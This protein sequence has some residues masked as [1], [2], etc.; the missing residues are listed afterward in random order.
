MISK[1][2]RILF[3]LVIIVVILGGFVPNYIEIAMSPQQ[4]N[5]FV[6]WSSDLS[7]DIIITWEFLRFKI[8]L[9][10]M[11][12]LQRIYQTHLPILPSA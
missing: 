4:K 5:P 8:V 7:S 2:I 12:K 10:S 11:A 9:Y 6:C 3:S 1:R